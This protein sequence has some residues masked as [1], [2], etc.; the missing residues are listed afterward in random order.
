GAAAGR[1]ERR[2]RAAPADAL[3]P[4][5]ARG[6]G[7]PPGSWAGRGTGTARPGRRGRDGLVP[8][9]AGGC[10]LLAPSGDR[11][12]AQLRRTV[13]APGPRRQRRL[14]LAGGHGLGTASTPAGRGAV[15]R[16]PGTLEHDLGAGPGHR[17][18][19]LGLLLPGPPPRR[20]G[21][22]P[23][24]AGPVPPRPGSDALARVLC[25]ARP[26]RPGPQLLRGLRHRPGGPCGRGAGDPA[27]HPR[28]R[29]GAG[30]EGPGTAGELGGRRTPGRAGGRHPL[31]REPPAPLRL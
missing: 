27:P 15:S 26:S 2:G 28:P 16:R 6:P 29:A 12:G 13:A 8:A 3:D 18:V 19:R 1:R 9:R 5:R 11:G 4:R 17:P 10:G 30:G 25:P 14:V 24:V 7:A 31:D 23:A 22:R 21:L 20:R